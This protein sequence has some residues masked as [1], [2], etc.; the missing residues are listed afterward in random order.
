MLAGFAK[1]RDK[2]PE[3][4]ATLGKP[5]PAQLIHYYVSKLVV[6]SKI[7]A[8]ARAWLHIFIYKSGVEQM[9]K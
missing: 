4:L 7:T 5:Q 1:E 2:E 8:F 9:L 3:R 6:E